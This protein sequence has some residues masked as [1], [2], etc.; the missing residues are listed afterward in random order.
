MEYVGLATAHVPHGSYGVYVEITGS[1][2]K[3]QDLHVRGSSG[4]NV[5]LTGM[6][7]S[8]PRNSYVDPVIVT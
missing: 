1:T 5:A 2:W 3:L 8:T 4:V 7:P 6:L